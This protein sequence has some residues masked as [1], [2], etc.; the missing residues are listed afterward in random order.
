MEHRVGQAPKTLLDRAKARGLY[1]ASKAGDVARWFGEEFQVARA[2]AK[3]LVH[4]RYMHEPTRERADD[5]RPDGIA[6]RDE[7]TDIAG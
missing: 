6:Q 2:R 5:V 3:E 7:L 4:V 1:A